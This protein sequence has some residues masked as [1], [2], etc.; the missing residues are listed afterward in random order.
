MTTSTPLSTTLS[1]LS[2]QGAEPSPTSSAGRVQGALLMAGSC[3]PVMGAVLIAPVLQRMQ[4][5]FAGVPG[6]QAL[7]PMALT[8]PALAVGLLAPFAGVI[9]DRLGRKR[10]LVVATVVYALLGTAPLWLDSLPALVA[11]RALLGIAEAAIMTCC[12]TLIGDYYDGRAREKYLALQTVCSALAATAFFAIGGGLGST[13]WRT[14]FVAYG[15]S[16]LIAPLMALLLPAPTRPGAEAEEAEADA[17]TGAARPMPWRALAPTCLLTLFGAVVFYTVP[18][19]TAF[20]LKAVHVEDTA[21]VGL[22]SAVSSLATVGGAAFFSRRTELAAGLLPWQFVIAATGFG[23]IAFAGNTPVLL[24]GSVIACFGSGMLLPSLLTRAMNVLDFEDRG[25]GTGL[26]T[27][28]FFLGSF[29][30]PLLLLAV[31]ALVGTLALAVGVLG[32]AAAVLGG[33]LLLRTPAE[34]S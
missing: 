22:V 7:V 15:I 5:H 31:K 2:E 20:L 9:V 13:G 21:I 4:D 16:L 34:Q 29:L 1:E 11:S 23:I 8:A 27:G 26:W 3:L 14:P 32:L 12:T 25:R 10:L 33:L 28:S 30:C 17:A 19:E 6:A 24:I 18:V